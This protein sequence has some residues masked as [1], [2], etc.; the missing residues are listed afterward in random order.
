M[1]PLYKKEKKKKGETSVR[2]AFSRNYHFLIWELPFL[3]PDPTIFSIGKSADVTILKYYIKCV[4]VHLFSDC[5]TDLKGFSKL[6]NCSPK[7]IN[8]FFCFALSMGDDMF[9]FVHLLLTDVFLSP[10]WYG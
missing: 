4:L 7:L 3:M 10:G 6:W 8:F 9:A 2:E 5:M 1:G